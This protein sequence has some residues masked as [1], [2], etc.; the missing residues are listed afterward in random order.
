M[1]LSVASFSP[2]FVSS[3]NE[4]KEVFLAVRHHKV[5]LDSGIQ[6]AFALLLEYTSDMEAE[7]FNVNLSRTVSQ[8]NY[9]SN[10]HLSFPTNGTEYET[11]D[12]AIHYL[13]EIGIPLLVIFG[14]LGNMLS[15]VVFVSTHLRYQ[16]S[17]VYLA[18]LN[19]VDTGFLLNLFLTWFSWLDIRLFHRQGWCQMVIYFTF[20]FGF[21]SVW[22]VV[23][24]TV[25][26]FIV[27]FRPL[28][29]QQWCTRR[30]AKIVLCS[31][32][33]FAVIFYSFP[34]W[35]A[36]V[37]YDGAHSRCTYNPDYRLFL[38][39][40]T[41]LDTLITLVIPSLAIVILNGGITYKICH[42]F[43]IRFHVNGDHTAPC[44]SSSSSSSNPHEGK[45]ADIPLRW[46]PTPVAKKPDDNSS[47]S[48]DRC[49]AA[50]HHFRAG[51]PT[52]PPDGDVSHDRRRAAPPPC[53]WQMEQH[54][55]ANRRMRQ[56]RTTRTL[57]IVSTV[58]VMLNL[59]SHAF[60]IYYVMLGLDLRRPI[61]D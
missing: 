14:C 11:F 45:D 56:I 3:R 1:P 21:L 37:D 48:R 43:S 5:K 53:V 25:E 7:A 18:F 22:T 16:S 23:A 49:P 8:P 42:F 13:N 2:D 31:L 6:L 29:R 38:M 19:V 36:K 59:P 28:R 46:P 44:T 52:R 33:A 34:L 61:G 35:C 50:N 54:S 58:F 27:V 10:R 41:L 40:M 32:T 47:G 15:L 26:R 24:F 39:I 17:S 12:R 30:R 9:T 55:Q 20:V 4:A 57:L 51:C 60:R